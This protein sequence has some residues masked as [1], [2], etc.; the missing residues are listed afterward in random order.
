MLN[1]EQKN[2]LIKKLDEKFKLSGNPLKCPM[3]ANANFTIADGYFNNTLQENLSSISLGGTSI[4]TIGIVCTNCG[5]L[6]Q[7]ALGIINALPDKDNE[8]VK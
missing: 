7:H 5:F 3:C 8:G 6:S 2:E 1:E 4:P